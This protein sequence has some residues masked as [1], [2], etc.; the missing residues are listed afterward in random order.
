MDGDVRGAVV[1]SYGS[2][3]NPGGG[4]SH[5]RVRAGVGS[6]GIAMYVVYVRSGG[7]KGRGVAIRGICS[8]NDATGDVVSEGAKGA[9]TMGLLQIR[10]RVRSLGSMT[11]WRCIPEEVGWLSGSLGGIEKGQ[12]R[13]NWAVE[14]KRCDVYRVDVMAEFSIHM[15]RV[16]SKGGGVVRVMCEAYGD[17]VGC[18]LGSEPRT[19]PELSSCSDYVWKH[20][21]NMKV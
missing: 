17:E 4:R 14:L 13:S 2:S 3:K 10:M 1:S 8:S 20:A 18:M 12:G 9:E 6:T 19:M 5:S 11:P 7:E 21:D 16:G 15:L